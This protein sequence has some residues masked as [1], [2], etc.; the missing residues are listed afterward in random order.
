MTKKDPLV[1]QSVLIDRRIYSLS[2][3]KK[4][5]KKHDFKLTFYGKGVEKSENFFRFRQMAPRR[6]KPDKYVTKEIAEGIKL[7][8]GNLKSN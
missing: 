7:V 8:L 5:I 4:W 1:A 6:F 2:E 3:A